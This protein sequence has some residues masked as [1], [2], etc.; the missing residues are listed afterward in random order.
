[1]FGGVASIQETIEGLFK[2]WIIFVSNILFRKC[3]LS[4]SIDVVSC[5]WV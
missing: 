2:S 1:L 4:W 5:Q 3:R